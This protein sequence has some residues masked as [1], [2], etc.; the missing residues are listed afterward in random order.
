V[1][2]GAFTGL[3]GERVRVREGRQRERGERER[4]REERE[5]EFNEC[6]VASERGAQRRRRAGQTK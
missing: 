2:L 1:G 6:F 4:E 3:L 5:R